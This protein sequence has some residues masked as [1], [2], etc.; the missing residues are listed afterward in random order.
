ME[1]EERSGG[2]RM[3]EGLNHLSLNECGGGQKYRRVGRAAFVDQ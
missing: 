2:G 1:V 3:C